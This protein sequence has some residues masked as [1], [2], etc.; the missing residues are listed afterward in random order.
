LSSRRCSSQVGGEE[1][2]QPGRATGDF[3]LSLPA[4]AAE[5][6]G[7]QSF[8]V[9]ASEGEEPRGH[10]KHHRHVVRHERKVSSNAQN[11]MRQLFHKEKQGTFDSFQFLT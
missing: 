6:R 8:H 5:R 2:L 10:E 4:V 3:Q 9:M 7:E 11:R 1:F